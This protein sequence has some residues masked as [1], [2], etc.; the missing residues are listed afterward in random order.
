MQNKNIHV[1]TSPE[2]KEFFSL[3]NNN[4]TFGQNKVLIN[5][6]DLSLISKVT[7]MCLVVNLGTK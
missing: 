5:F 2:P 7:D 3:I 6:D 4:I 1:N